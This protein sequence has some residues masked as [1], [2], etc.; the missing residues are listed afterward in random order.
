[1][2]LAVECS[3]SSWIQCDEWEVEQKGWTELHWTLTKNAMDRWAMELNKCVGESK[4]LL[5]SIRY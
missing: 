2:K 4:F 5:L 3:D 1:M